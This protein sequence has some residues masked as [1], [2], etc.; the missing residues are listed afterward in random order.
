[1]SPAQGEVVGAIDASF[2]TPEIDVQVVKADGGRSEMVSWRRGGS[3]LIAA[4]GLVLCYGVRPVHGQAGAVPLDVKRPQY[5]NLRFDEDWSIRRP[6][7]A[8]RR[9]ISGIG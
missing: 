5:E 4:L 2:A 1:M 6:S 7:T 3:A 8:P 9:V